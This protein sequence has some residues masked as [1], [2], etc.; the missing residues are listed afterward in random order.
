MNEM[1]NANRL[2]FKQ[3]PENW[4]RPRDDLILGYATSMTASPLLACG[5]KLFEA[6][7]SAQ[8]RPLWRMLAKHSAL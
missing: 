7:E 2:V 4:R 5:M 6:R 1:T 3:P 8:N